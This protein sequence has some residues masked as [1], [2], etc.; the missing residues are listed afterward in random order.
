[1]T[2]LLCL[3][4][5]GCATGQGSTAPLLPEGEAY[6]ASLG[7]QLAREGFKPV[8][9]YSS[10][11]KRARDTAAIVL[12]ELGSSVPLVQLRQ[13]APEAGAASA[14]E[15]LT[16]GS[17]PAGRVLVVTHL[18]LVAQLVEG[19]TGKHVDFMP[20]TFAEIELGADGL[21]GVLRRVL[22]SV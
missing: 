4:R 9:A 12:G 1:M 10:T 22:G 16:L 17:L 19:L 18:P 15:A 7:R 3:L 14:L 20:G 11:L 21:G 13:L 8:A 2:T 6:V 5:H